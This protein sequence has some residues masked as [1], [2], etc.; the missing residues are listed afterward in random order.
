MQFR[1]AILAALSLGLAG[2]VRADEGMWTFD[3]FPAARVE[4]AYGV[5]IDQAWLD[6]VR[7]ASVRLTSGCSASI[8]S[9][10]GLVLT[11]HHCVVECVQQLS[12]PQT[13]YVK[14]GFL[15]AARAEER[16]CPAMQAEVLETITDLTPVIAK[17]TEGK[18]GEAFVRARDSATAAAEVAGCLKDQKRRCQV[19]SLYRGGQYKLYR[20]RKYADV[21][22]VFAP[23]FAT[24]FFGG[25]PDNFNF[26]RF[27]LDMGFLRLYENGRPVKA[28]QH[29]TWQSR[30]P[31]EGELL[32]V[33]GNPGGTDRAM[34]VAQL[35]TQRDLVIPVGQLQRAEL[36]GRLIR[37]SEEGPE[38]RRIATD[39]LFGLEN[40]FKV[41]FGRQ[42][43]L[44]DPALMD[45]R[46]A[47]EA[48][49]KAKVA[50]DP[51]LAAAVGDPWADITRAQTAYAEDYL[52]YRQL[53]ANAGSLSELFSYARQLVRAA[54]E[55][56]MPI[57][58][59]LPEYSAG[60]LA[61][62]Q[63]QILDPKPVDAPLEEL[64]LSFWLSKTR[65]YLTTDDP[66]VKLLLD[67]ESPEALAARL[68]KETTLAGAEARKALWDGGLPAIQASTDPLIRFVLRT[69]PDA[70]AIR[71]AWEARVSGPSDEAAGRLAR[72]R[73]AAFGAAAYPDATFTLRLSY[74]KVA[75]WTWR[76]RTIGPFTTFAGL[77]DRATGAEPYQLAPRWIAAKD[78]LD[79][80]TVFNFVTTNDIIGGN[81]GSPV[82]NVHGEVLGAAFDGNIHSLGGNY[83][84]DPVLNRTV[85]VST[86]AATEALEKVYGRTA[87][88]KELTGR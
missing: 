11:N 62:V 36:R 34:T 4:K 79:P 8:V 19:V 25:D 83:G 35:E 82:V 49:L 61:L 58:Q 15:T 22:L 32:F 81:S 76:G 72:A 12:A 67:R 57:T 70:R 29:L 75:G 50:A 21:R 54:Q 88:V 5:T 87:L 3:A 60:R 42:F 52:R 43:A 7:G 69:D 31:L 16:Q 27:N 17:A 28:A 73:F 51:A 85:V 63:K 56:A 23:E 86:A 46:R 80:T 24:A 13:D 65:E 10:E 9:P 55:R 68:V 14:E 20:Y 64:Y 48:E 33:S 2:P 66:S 44:N 78:K 37:F 26:P 1:P 30:A 40:G 84:Y 71:R 39:P 38:H 77:Y 47:A 41:F 74:G 45:A 18:T 6:R 53:E 59:R